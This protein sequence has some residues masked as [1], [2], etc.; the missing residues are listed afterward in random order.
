MAVT[1]REGGGL[2][3]QTPPPPQIP[4][5]PQKLPTP[6][7]LWKISFFFGR[8]GT[9][10]GGGGGLKPPPPPEIPK[11]L[12]NRANLTPIVKIVKNCWI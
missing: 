7:P 4:R 5:P 12:Q 8:G 2:G 3:V 9:G 6:P 10:G 11:A 1:Y